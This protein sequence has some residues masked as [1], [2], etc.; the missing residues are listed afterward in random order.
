[1]CLREFLADRL[2]SC[3]VELGH[4][5][6]NRTQEGSVECLSGQLLAPFVQVVA[7]GVDFVDRDE[8]LQ[9]GE[10]DGLLHGADVGKDGLVLPCLSFREGSAEEED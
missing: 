10:A 6:G 3:Q 4:I 1:M 5:V 2:E 9:V 7:C 8:G